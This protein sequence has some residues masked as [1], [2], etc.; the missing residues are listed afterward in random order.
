[1]TLAD[2]VGGPEPVDDRRRPDGAEYECCD[3]NDRQ[4]NGLKSFHVASMSG[5]PKWMLKISD[6]AVVTCVV[7]PTSHEPTRCPRPLLPKLKM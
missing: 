6:F 3:H 5:G 1:M 7:S 2:G 4:R